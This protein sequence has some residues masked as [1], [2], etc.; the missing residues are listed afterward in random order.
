MSADMDDVRPLSLPDLLVGI[1][2]TAEDLDMI[3]ED[4]VH[5]R[6]ATNDPASIVELHA[7]TDDVMA[8]WALAR[9]ALVALND[10]M[11]VTR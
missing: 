2:H 7:I 6:H 11:A 10:Y 8:A 9:R 4:L 3:G 1:E 5:V